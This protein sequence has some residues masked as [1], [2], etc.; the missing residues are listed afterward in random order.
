MSDSPRTTIK[1]VA[2]AAGV[3]HATVSR[4]LR[5]DP[6]IAAATVAK[7]KAAAAGLGYVPDPMMRALSAY[8]T[9]LRPVNFKETIAFLW[10]EHSSREVAASPYLRRYI[11]GARARATEL[12]YRIDEFFLPAQKPAA[13]VKVLN[14]R[15]I[16]GLVIGL[17][18]RVSATHMRLPLDQFAVSAITNAIKH[19]RLHR[20]GHDHFGG[21]RTALH[22]LKRLG[23]RRIAYL[24]AERHERLLDHRY[25]SSF[26]A[27]HPLGPD[28]ARPLVRFVPL[29]TTAEIHKFA[30]AVKPDVLVFPFTINES[31]IPLEDGSAIP[32]VSLDGLPFD[33]K[34]AGINQLT[35]FIAASAVDT[36]VEQLIHGHFG[37]PAHR[38]NVLSDGIWIDHPSCPPIKR[39]PGRVKNP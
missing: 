32:V 17:I 16:R 21:M 6:R 8:R 2:R 39:P 26:L 25:G 35:E 36:V 23:Y 5:D 3:H 7:V 24:G 31:T 10:L 12:G 20:F 33:G 22:H 38:K 13:L 27:H 30:N 11:E 9:S 29:V 28:K 37:I 18:T 15:G 14:A 4:A 19:P 1:D 34:T